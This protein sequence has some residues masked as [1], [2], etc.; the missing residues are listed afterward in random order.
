MKRQTLGQLI[1]DH[2]LGGYQALI[3]GLCGVVA[4][5]DGF[6]TQS[7]AFVA[8]I[9]AKE[10]GIQTSVFGS[11]FAAGLAGGLVGAILFGLF[12]DRVGRRLTV[13][14]TV[15]IFAVGSLATVF[16]GSPMELTICRLLTGLGL[17][18]AMPSIIALAAEYAP[19]RSRA[20][21][22]TA[23]FCGFPLGA[24]I[25]A[26]GSGPLIEAHGWKAVFIAGGLAPLLVLP[27]FALIAPE[28]IAWLCKR[29]RG[30]DVE[31]ILAK[32]KRRD[33]WDEDAAVADA[34]VTP[35]SL[36][37]VFRDGRAA[38]SLLLGLAFF[39]SLLLVY[40]LVSWVPTL[41]VQAGH[42]MRASVM[43]AAVLNFA[44][45]VGSLAIARAN[46]RLNPHRIVAAAYAIGGAGALMFAL[47]GDVGGMIFQFSLVAGLFCIGAQVTLVSLG[48]AAYPVEIRGTGVGF[49]MAAG[50]VGAICGPLV[51]AT[52]IDGPRAG[53]V[54]AL[55]VAVA[56]IMTSVA[57]LVV[58]RE[59]R[60][61]ANPLAA[62]V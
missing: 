10:W 12:A 37:S 58:G 41:A 29:G 40:L 46:D 53:W 38:T 7:V 19:A 49:L 43:T 47:S 45:I 5:L 34:N 9:M 48:S 4:L 2:K 54:L 20:T 33:L 8:P 18:G 31:K 3:I 39:L 42:T 6:D 23:M 13:L 56:S 15:A 26:I 62:R 17:G 44:G 21:L 25:G 1:D 14:V 27:V 35:V 57:I 61:V 28:S 59:T 16:T 11:V 24:V 52:A 32:L 22:V 36:A 55:V 51:G 50:R 60:R 30:R